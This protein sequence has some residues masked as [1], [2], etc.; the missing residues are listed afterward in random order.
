MA[1]MIQC[2]IFDRECTIF[3]IFSTSVLEVH[4][5][6][7]A[8]RH[9]ESSCYRRQCG[10]NQ[11]K[12]QLPSI[13]FISCTHNRNFLKLIILEGGEEGLLFFYQRV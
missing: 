9:S 11:L 12:Y 6:A 2:N 5:G 10:H 4:I 3:V 13:R 7:H 1:K 8:A